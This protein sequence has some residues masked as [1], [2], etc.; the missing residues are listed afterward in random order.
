MSIHLRSTLE[1]IGGQSENVAFAYPPYST[2][3]NW[4][5]VVPGFKMASFS[6]QSRVREL[7]DSMT[8]GVV[9][10]LGKSTTN[11]LKYLIVI[12]GILGVV[13]AKTRKIMG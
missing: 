1:K 11:K 2:G 12:T 13:F 9:R 4:K 6:E 3:G 8:L 10:S 7:F 5:F